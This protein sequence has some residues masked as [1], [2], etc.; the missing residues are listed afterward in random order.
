MERGRVIIY[1]F[2]GDCRHRL[3]VF[4]S[5]HCLFFF[6][7]GLHFRMVHFTKAIQ[8]SMHGIR[9]ARLCSS[10]RQMMFLRII[11]WRLGCCR[12]VCP[13]CPRCRVT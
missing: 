12:G 2:V 10:I 7:A 13:S 6:F 9:T 11:Q 4:T 1:C 5:F 3:F 8:S